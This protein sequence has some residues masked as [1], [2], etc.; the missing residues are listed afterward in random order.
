MAHIQRRESTIQ[1]PKSSREAIAKFYSHVER[2]K[3]VKREAHRVVEP[4][5]DS[6]SAP[7]AKRRR[8]HLCPSQRS[9]MQ[10]QFCSNCFKNVCNEHSTFTRECSACKK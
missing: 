9:K 5:A 4:S 1:L 6:S 8:C 3:G 7:E 2:S 10:K